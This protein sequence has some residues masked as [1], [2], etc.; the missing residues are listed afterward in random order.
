VLPARLKT[1]HL[2]Q[3]TR[4]RHNYKELSRGLHVW[5]PFTCR[6]TWQ[7][8]NTP[9]LPCQATAHHMGTLACPVDGV[10]LHVAAPAAW[11]T[12]TLVAV[13]GALGGSLV[14]DPGC[15]SAQSGLDGTLFW[16][17]PGARLHD[18][19]DNKL[20]DAHCIWLCFEAPA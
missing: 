19:I 10:T 9:H 15:D 6:A 18:L 3:Q 2:L 11:A 7:P 12:T 17:L 4:L 20:R 5:L 1:Q 16:T 8:H 13:P 14:Y